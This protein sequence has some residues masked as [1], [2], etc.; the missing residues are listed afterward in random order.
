MVSFESMFHDLATTR[1]RYEDREVLR[2][3]AGE[4]VT[5][6][7]HLNELRAAIRRVEGD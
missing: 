2:L 5:L 4:R 7:A 1:A 3:S 6:R